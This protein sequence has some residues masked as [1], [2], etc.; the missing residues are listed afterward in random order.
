M[1]SKKCLTPVALQ[2]KTCIWF[3]TTN[4]KIE[5]IRFNVSCAVHTVMNKQIWV[6]YGTKDSQIWDTFAFE[7]VCF[8]L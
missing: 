3:R 6:S 4:A 8:V 2:N 5:Q 7:L 1:N